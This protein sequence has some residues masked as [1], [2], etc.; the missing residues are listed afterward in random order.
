[1]RSER[2]ETASRHAKHMP[3]TRTARIA[4]PGPAR[5]AV[6]GPTAAKTAWIAGNIAF[7]LSRGFERSRDLIEIISKSTTCRDDGALTRA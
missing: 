6:P 3:L 5:V 4:V 2:R 7:V 1:M